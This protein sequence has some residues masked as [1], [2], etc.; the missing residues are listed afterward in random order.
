MRYGDLPQSEARSPSQ[1]MFLAEVRRRES[2]T[3][4]RNRHWIGAFY[5]AGYTLECA[6]KAVLARNNDNKLPGHYVTHN[7][8]VLRPAAMQIV[9]D[10]AAAALQQVP[11]WTHLLR[12]DCKAPRPDSV[13]R[14][15]NLVRE[16]Y[17]CLSSHV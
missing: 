12:Y 16:A 8:L 11:F 14:F 13:V 10:D 9:S 3:L 15:V 6:L 5:L 2:F 4:L 17:R 7:I 1:F